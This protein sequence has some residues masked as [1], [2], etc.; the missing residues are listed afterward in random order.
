M[1]QA[2]SCWPP[3][4]NQNENV[5][6]HHSF[7]PKWQR[8]HIHSMSEIRR[9]LRFRLVLQL[10]F[11]A[12]VQCKTRRCSEA[13]TNPRFFC[14]IAKPASEATLSHCKDLSLRAPCGD[15]LRNELQTSRLCSSSPLEPPSWRRRYM[16]LSPPSAALRHGTRC[17]AMLDAGA[18]E[19]VLRKV[20]S[21]C[22]TALVQLL[23]LR[24]APEAT[25]TSCKRGPF[26]PC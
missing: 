26:R 16:S 25:R 13:G 11:I 10:S 7:N 3:F 5:A 1:A 18:P 22:C 12:Q 19:V 6:I 14:A 8:E 15:S 4:K 9:H 21:S 23:C 2:V 20:V 17:E 24:D